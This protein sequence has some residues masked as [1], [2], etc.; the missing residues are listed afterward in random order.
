M[1]HE[2]IKRVFAP[3]VSGEDLLIGNGQAVSI[4]FFGMLFGEASPTPTY[5]ELMA[6]DGGTRGYS[7]FF[8]QCKTEGIL[9]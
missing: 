7:G 5:V 1:T 4:D 9:I 8:D 2:D 3:H 6:I